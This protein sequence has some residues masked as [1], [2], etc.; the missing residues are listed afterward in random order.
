MPPLTPSRMRAMTAGWC[1]LAVAAAAAVAVPDLAA[2]D[3]LEGDRQV[4]LGARVDHRGREL[5]ERSLAEV[6][7]VRVDLPRALGGD[8]HTRV[9]RVDVL[10][11]LV[12]A[13]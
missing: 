7:V 4:V 2:R 6:V 1:R 3:L 9:R 12:D 10:Q 5:L 13:G 11:Q 8:D